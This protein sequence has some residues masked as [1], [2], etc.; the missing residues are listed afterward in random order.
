[1]SARAD[2]KASAANNAATAE[3]ILLIFIFICSLCTE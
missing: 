1:L 2:V 3:I